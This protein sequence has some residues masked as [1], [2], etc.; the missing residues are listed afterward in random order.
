V[1]VEGSYK[2]TL[3]ANV[4]KGW[5][6]TP[7]E[8][9]VW[10]WIDIR[11][12]NFVFDGYSI[13]ATDNQL[14]NIEQVT[15]ATTAGITGNLGRTGSQT[16]TTNTAGS[17]I[18][19]VLSNVTGSSAGV[20]GSVSNT[21]TTTAGINQQYVK[22]GADIVPEELRIYRESERNL[23]VAGNTLIALTMRLDPT[24]WRGVRPERTNRVTKLRL[25]GADGSFANPADLPIEVTQN[26]APPHCAL[27]ARVVMYYQDRRPRDGRSYV[28]GQQEADYTKT[29]YG[30]I[31]VTIVSAD[32]V[33]KPSWRI[34]PRISPQAAL[35]IQGP[36]EHNN[37]IDFTSYEQAHDFLVWL[38]HYGSQFYGKMEPPI[39][40]AGLRLSSGVDGQPL[41][42]PPYFV[43]RTPDPPDLP[44]RCAGMA[45][46]PGAAP[47]P[48]AYPAA[49][50]VQ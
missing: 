23:D 26:E 44:S 39:G 41:F 11:P 22:L 16:E 29:S 15:N 48:S 38:T 18:S 32:E 9:L 8:R 7:G 20:S 50:P 30:P 24:G 49:A 5:G 3:V 33:R 2:R 21:Y 35:Q 31:P 27:T 19:R 12:D 13:L 6:A 45:N 43:E 37:P 17:P 4:T 36:F 42:P 47:G 1:T 28:E 34:Y 14:L 10:T 46:L 40:K 25:L